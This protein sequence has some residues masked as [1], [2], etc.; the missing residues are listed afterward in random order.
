MFVSTFGAGMA[1]GVPDV[2]KTP[3]FAIP[4]P[5]PN[6]ASNA[7][8]VPGYFT[9]LILGLPE[10]NLLSMHALTSG[11]EAGTMGGVVSQIFSGP[12]R[13]VLGSQAVF[14]AGVPVQRLCDP[15]I[16]NLCNCPGI[17]AVP[18]QTIKLALR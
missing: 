18:S 15:T 12:A 13:A 8:V 9:V 2:C 1:I 16:H 4:V 5:L 11:D 3:P 6:I 14:V 10:L 17:V 7:M